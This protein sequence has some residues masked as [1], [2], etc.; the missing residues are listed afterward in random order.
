MPISAL[1]VKTRTDPSRSTRS[2]A[3]NRLG[4]GEV[5][6]GDWARSCGAIEESTRLNPISRPPASLTKSRLEMPGATRRGWRSRTIR[7]CLARRLTR[8]AV[9]GSENSHVAAAAAHE[10]L[11]RRAHLGVGRPGTLVQQR[12]RRHHPAVQAVPALE[13]LFVDE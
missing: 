5:G 9:H 12:L 3:S 7:L 13:C 6:A 10:A 2:H 11:E 1:P 8:R 4:G